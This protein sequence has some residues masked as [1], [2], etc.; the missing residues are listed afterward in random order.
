MNIIDDKLWGEET[1]IYL[2]RLDAAAEVSEELNAIYKKY[3]PGC[4]FSTSDPSDSASIALQLG[5]Y[6][7]NIYSTSLRVSME[8][9]NQWRKGIFVLVPMSVRFI[10]ENW[11]AIHFARQTLDRLITHNDVEREKNRVKRL[12]FGSKNFPVRLPFIGEATATNESFSVMCFIKSLSDVSPKSI[13]DYNFL[14]EASH[15]NFIQSYYFQLAGPPLPNWSNDNYKKHGH[16]LLERTV[17]A[18]EQAACGIQTDMI[19]ILE[20]AS[21]H[22]DSEMSGS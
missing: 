2:K 12:L 6:A 11:G 5:V 18:I 20:L 10:I 17:Q 7:S 22:V 8:I 14:S 1:G 3:W 4:F 19:H 13:E 16:Q 15:P 21:Q 9:P